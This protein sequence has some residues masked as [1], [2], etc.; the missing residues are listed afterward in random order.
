MYFIYLMKI[1]YLFYSFHFNSIRRSNLIYSNQKKNYC[2]LI[3]IRLNSSLSLLLSFVAARIIK[4]HFKFIRNFA[5]S[6]YFKYF[7]L[8]IN[9]NFIYF[10][11]F[12]FK[13]ISGLRILKCLHYLHLNYLQDLLFFIIMKIFHFGLLK[14]SLLYFP[15]WF[16]IGLESVMQFYLQKNLKFNRNLYFMRYFKI[17]HIKYFLR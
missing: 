9:L 14:K 2:E 15:N 17:Y 16:K 3:F 13:L 7:Q 11:F 10:Y 5:I 8:I 1:N 6:F 12:L 4:I